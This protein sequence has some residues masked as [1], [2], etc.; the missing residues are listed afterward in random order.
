MQMPAELLSMSSTQA[1]AY[2]EREEH[3]Y[4]LNKKKGVIIPKFYVLVCTYGRQINC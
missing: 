3:Q 4:N 1:L 2:F